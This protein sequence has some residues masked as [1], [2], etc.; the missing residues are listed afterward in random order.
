[1]S[2]SQRKNT[3][4][5]PVKKPQKSPK[6]SPKSPPQTSNTPL[7]RSQNQSKAPAKAS[8]N[9]N[10]EP[11]L[12]PLQSSD[13]TETTNPTDQTA[14]LADLRA[15][16]NDFV[17]ERKWHK[18]HSPRNLAA[19]ISI[20]AAELLEHFQWLTPEDALHKSQND[21]TF[22]HEVGEEMADVLLYL[23][24][25]ANTLQLD[26]TQTVH[27]K[28][29]KNRLKYPADKFQGHYQRPLRRR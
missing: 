19:S 15:L 26:L 24:S 20:E 23:L 16:M 2:P 4:S 21:K 3:P 17:A 7:R 25:L 1:M 12:Q 29:K 22:R 9:T 13:Q 5:T 6:N 28:M 18:F 8:A 14:T 27:N 10:N 11:D